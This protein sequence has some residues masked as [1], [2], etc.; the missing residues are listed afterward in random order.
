MYCEFI[1]KISN[2]DFYFSTTLFRSVLLLAINS[3]VQTKC[4]YELDE[5][6][7]EKAPGIDD[8]SKLNYI[9]ATLMEIQ[10][11]SIVAQSSLPHRLM[12]DTLIDQYNFKKDT[13]FFSNLAKF[14][15][16][17]VQFP[18]PRMFK[19]ERF[20]NSNGK[21]QR[22]DYLVPFGIG[23]RVCMGETLAKNELFIFFV[24]LLQRTNIGEIKCKLP[25]PDDFT[26]YWT[27]V[28]KPYD[29]SISPRIIEPTVK[30]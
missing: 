3:E 12:Q 1:L 2:N 10:R 19:P 17:P 11:F 21:V 18:E 27:R 20:L 15:N 6:L 26:L 13:F 29:I 16:D 25:D 8:M 4:Q 30:P 14:S 24:R 22:N 28:P 23:K 5:F 9:M 7:D